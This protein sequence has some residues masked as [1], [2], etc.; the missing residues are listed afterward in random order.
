MDK[1]TQDYFDTILKKEPITLSE[2]EIKFLRARRSYLKKVQLEEY[3]NVLNPKQT[4][5]PV[6]ETVKNKNANTK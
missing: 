5:P 1:R 2:V 3:D 4:K 6:K